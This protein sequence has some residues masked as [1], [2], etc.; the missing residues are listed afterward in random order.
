MNVAAVANAG[1]Q[2]PEACITDIRQPSS[3]KVI[4]TLPPHSQSHDTRKLNIVIASNML[5]GSEPTSEEVSHAHARA[6]KNILA[7]NGAGE[8]STAGVDPS[9]AQSRGRARS[10]CP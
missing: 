9:K 4:Y 1:F 2:L 8:L 3:D 10:P 5:A 7:N 6:G